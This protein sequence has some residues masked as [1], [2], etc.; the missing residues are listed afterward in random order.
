M[1]WKMM[2]F[3]LLILATNMFGQNQSAVII[4]QVALTNQTAYIPPTELVA[5]TSNAL[6][7]I[8]AY[9]EV[10]STVSNEKG[11]LYYL[12]I[13][14]TDASPTGLVKKTLT[15]ADYTTPLWNQM[16]VIASDLGGKPLWYSVTDAFSL[17]P[18]V[19]FNVYITVEQLQ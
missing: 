3:T 1:N 17:P 12:N 4:Q 18:R 13:G 5:P 2:L 19:P 10:L 14:W 8:S 11:D 7:R 9:L 16:T 6:Y 15:V